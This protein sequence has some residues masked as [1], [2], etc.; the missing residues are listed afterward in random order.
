MPFEPTAARLWKRLPPEDRLS[1]AQSLVAEQA[2]ETL[3]PAIFA[4]AQ[5]RKMRPQSARVMPQDQQARA[6]AGVANPGEAVA[7]S[8]LVALHI[9]HRR[10]LLGTFLDACQIPHEDGILTE[11]AEAVTVTD[12]AMRAAAGKLR[13]QFPEAEVSVYLNTLWL[14]D[15]ERWGALAPLG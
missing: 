11:A 2:V 5:A 13:E 6:L 1:A 12:E 9:G 15:P 10:P 3:G 14:Q 8:L 7:S 4:I